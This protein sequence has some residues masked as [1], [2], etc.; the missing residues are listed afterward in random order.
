MTMSYSSL[1]LPGY[2]GTLHRLSYYFLLVYDV[3]KLA[4]LN[5]FST[6]YLTK[7]VYQNITLS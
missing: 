2:S 5:T 1:T 7:C 4:L 3:Y 6:F